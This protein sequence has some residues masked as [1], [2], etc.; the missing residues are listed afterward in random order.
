MTS[1]VQRSPTR[2]SAPAIGHG[3]RSALP[4]CGCLFD[5]LGIPTSIL[6]DLHLTSDSHRILQ[7]SLALRKSRDVAGGGQCERLLKP[8]CRNWIEKCRR[9]VASWNASRLTNSSGG[10]TRDP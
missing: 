2:S 9:R 6:S 1:S 7:Q 10:L 4:G 8:C 3:E 5:F